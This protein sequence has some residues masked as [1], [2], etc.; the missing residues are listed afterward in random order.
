MARLDLN[1]IAFIC[2]VEVTES[3]YGVTNGNVD[4][5]S[6]E[7]SHVVKS[8]AVQRIVGELTIYDDGIAVY[9]PR[10]VGGATQN[11]VN[12]VANFVLSV[13]E[14]NNLSLTVW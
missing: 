5:T 8:R 9:Q 1:D 3:D 10:A 7:L 12:V 11:D 4:Y 13:V 2:H 14:R 6:Y